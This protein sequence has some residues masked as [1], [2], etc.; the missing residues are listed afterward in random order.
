[1]TSK[2]VT[3]EL[4][5]KILGQTEL[6]ARIAQAQTLTKNLSELKGAAMKAGQLLS[7]D[8]GDF[9]PPEALE[10]LSG[11]QAEAKS[12]PLAELHPQFSSLAEARGLKDFEVLDQTAVAAAS[13]GQVHKGRLNGQDVAVKIQ[14]PGIRDAIDSDLNTL[15]KIVGSF[16][17]FAGKKFSIDSTFAELK[18]VLKQETDFSAEAQKLI[19]YGHY[20]KDYPEYKIPTPILDY[21]STSI[22]TMSWMPG[23]PI[24]TWIKNKP[25]QASRERMANMVLNLFCLEFADWGF[26]QT[27]PNFANFLV[28]EDEK[29]VCLDFGATIEY[30]RVFRKNYGELL[31][32]FRNGS[33][34]EI[35]EKAVEFGLLDPREN[36]EVQIAFKDLIKTSLEP[37]DPSKQPFEFR[38]SDFQKRTVDVNIRFNRILEFS[39]P[40]RQILFLHR[41]LGGV[42][43][44]VK[45]MDVRIDLM[46]YWK[47]MTNC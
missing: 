7:L 13:I 9:L 43:N 28:T 3:Q 45:T 12:L 35:F 11:L 6:S 47:K 5:R 37:F 41:K 22:L 24:R 10:I 8:A 16:L 34:S 23:I 21:T 30:D 1:M 33:T 15:Q 18:S 17:K 44:L 32:I 2:L 31:T 42:F 39:P 25:S 46:P 26:V 14:Y 20:L 29:L 4:G 38:D 36:R 27:D 40:P 19:R